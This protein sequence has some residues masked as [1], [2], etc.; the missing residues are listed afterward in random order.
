MDTAQALQKWLKLK[1]TWQI[2]HAYFP[3]VPYQSCISEPLFFNNLVS[4]NWAVL[5]PFN[6]FNKLNRTRSI[7][8]L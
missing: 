5:P 3:T 6:N 8:P 7:E 1:R 4:P 2:S